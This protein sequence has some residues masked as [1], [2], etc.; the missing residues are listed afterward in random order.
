[1]NYI[2]R[3]IYK[4]PYNGTYAKNYIYITDNN[5]ML[6]QTVL[7]TDE[8]SLASGEKLL[9]KFKDKQLVIRSSF[10]S[11]GTAYVIGSIATKHKNDSSIKGHFTVKLKDSSKL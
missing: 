8:M 3:Y 6:I 7:L 10:F 1:M 4:R 5:E 9:R 2:A 11:L